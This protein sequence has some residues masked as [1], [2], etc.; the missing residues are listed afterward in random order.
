MSA[1]SESVKMFGF[2]VYVGDE[3][4][5][6]DVGGFGSALHEQGITNPTIRLD[7]GVKVY[8]CECWWGAE[9]QVRAKIGDREVIEVDIRSVRPSAG[10]KEAEEQ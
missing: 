4:P 3:V 1:T 8:G 6:A 5:T 2:G 7:N 9:D 10:S